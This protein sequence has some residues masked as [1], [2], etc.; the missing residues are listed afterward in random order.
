MAAAAN[1][2]DVLDYLIRNNEDI[3]QTD[4]GDALFGL[5]SF[6]LGKTLLGQSIPGTD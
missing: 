3:D 2:V 6:H 4:I 1:M 5:L